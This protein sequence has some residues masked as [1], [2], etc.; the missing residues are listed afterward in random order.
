M[1]E[2]TQVQ[3]DPPHHLKASYTIRRLSLSWIQ[4]QPLWPANLM[5][6]DR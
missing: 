3:H 1:V 5:T 6:D 2:D 4:P